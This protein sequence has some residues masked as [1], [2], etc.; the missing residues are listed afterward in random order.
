[1]GYEID[2]KRGVANHYG[3]RTTD[4]SFGGQL[5]AD[6]LVKKAVWSFDYDNLPAP[7]TNNMQ[8]VIPAN[9]TIV[10]AKLYV[11][12]AWASTSTTTDLTVG[13]QQSD[14][15]EVDND[16]LVSATEANQTD[17]AVANKEITGA[18]AL[19]GLS[20]GGADCEVV[21]APTVDDLTAGSATLVVEYKTN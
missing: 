15:T 13:L 21:V 7:G 9:A 10:S 5:K 16:G 6:G 20:V 8:Y 1:M 12:V 17:L 11:D 4:S 19:V 2:A 3:V 14:G 18:G